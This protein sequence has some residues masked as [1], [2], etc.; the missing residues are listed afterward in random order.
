M[1]ESLSNREDRYRIESH[2]AMI[3]LQSRRWI[4]AKGIAFLGIAA[5]AAALM[6]LKS[7]SVQTAVLLVLL[8]WAAAGYKGRPSK[9]SREYAERMGCFEKR[10][11][12]LQL[13][14]KNKRFRARYRR[15]RLRRRLRNVPPPRI[16]FRW[17]SVLAF[18]KR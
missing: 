14:T 15:D 8:V 16:A 3:D 9:T 1:Q 18:S 12:R 13:V 11:T 2:P 17:V 10:V 7:P 5:I 6:L 4:V